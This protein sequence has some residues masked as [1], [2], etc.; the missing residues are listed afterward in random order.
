MANVPWIFND[1]LFIKKFPSQKKPFAWALLEIVV[2]YFVT[3][4][5]AL[6]TEIGRA[7]V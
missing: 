5:I 6:F 1:F 2:L 3:R 7:H 4:G